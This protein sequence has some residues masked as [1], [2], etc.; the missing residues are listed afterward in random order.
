MTFGI[1]VIIFAAGM[2]FGA[3]MLLFY[4]S[5]IPQDRINIPHIGGDIENKLGLARKRFG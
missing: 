1:G 5:K 2:I 4:A 3:V